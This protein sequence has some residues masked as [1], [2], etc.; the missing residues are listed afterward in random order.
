MARKIYNSLTK[1]M[2]EEWGITEI[3]WDEEAKD[4]Q[5]QRYWYKNNSKV[6]VMKT[7][8]ISNAVCKHKY[9]KAKAYPI[10]TFSY[11]QQ[12]ISLPLSRI[13][14]AWFNGEVKDGYVIDHIDNN[15]YNNRLENLQQLTQEDNLKKRFADNLNNSRNQYEAQKEAKYRIC[16]NCFLQGKTYSE[17]QAIL[18]ELFKDC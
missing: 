8:A 5:I 6:K 18:Y 11:N 17:T 16:H 15:P 12:V 10:V 4:W 2:L 14:Y 3:T 7:L 13:I 1:K 9:T